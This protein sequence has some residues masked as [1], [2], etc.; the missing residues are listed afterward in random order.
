[1]AVDPESLA[2][3]ITVVFEGSFILS[4]TYNRPEVVAEQLGH[5]RRYVALLF[6]R[7]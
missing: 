7:V 4:N 6:G 1:M 2:D 3:A 5:Y